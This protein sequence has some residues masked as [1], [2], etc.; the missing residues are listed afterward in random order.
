MMGARLEEQRVCEGELEASKTYQTIK[1]TI[2]SQSMW[3]P[4][5]AHTV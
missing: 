4:A 3:A 2:I 1:T 5:N